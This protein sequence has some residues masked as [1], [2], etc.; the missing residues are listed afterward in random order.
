MAV[1]ETGLMDFQTQEFVRLGV[2]GIVCVLGE[3]W[4]S[5]VVLSGRL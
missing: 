3:S 1:G 2:C 5:V 4:M